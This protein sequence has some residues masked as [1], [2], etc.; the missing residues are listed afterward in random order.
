MRHSTERNSKRYAI[1]LR[2]CALRDYRTG[3]VDRRLLGKNRGNPLLPRRVYPPMASHQ[4]LLIAVILASS[5]ASM[6]C[7]AKWNAIVKYSDLPAPEEESTVVGAY[8]AAP[9]D[10]QRSF[11]LEDSLSAMRR[12]LGESTPGPVRI[13]GYWEDSLTDE[14]EVALGDSL[15]SDPADPHVVAQV[16]S[17][18]GLAV[19]S[20]HAGRG[21]PAERSG[22][23][24]A[25]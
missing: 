7:I 3:A 25:L 11:A 14:I 4:P 6:S 23:P 20:G 9:E 8:W 19:E 21:Q 24:R 15:L 5:V 18:R 16:A 2:A 10:V 22:W 17:T 1:S 12:R 13:P